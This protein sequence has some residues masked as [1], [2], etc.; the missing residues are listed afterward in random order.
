MVDPQSKYPG[1]PPVRTEVPKFLWHHVTITWILL[2]RVPFGLLFL[3]KNKGAALYWG[4]K[5]G[6]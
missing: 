4:S 3:Q 5:E 2:I 6:P 1:P